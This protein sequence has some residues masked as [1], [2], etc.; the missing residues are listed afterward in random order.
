MIP[1]P[2]SP[3]SQAAPPSPLRSALLATLLALAL[4]AARGAPFTPG[5]FLV[6]EADTTS[7]E[8]ASKALFADEWA[9]TAAGRLAPVGNSIAL[10]SSGATPLTA[11]GQAADIGTVRPYSGSVTT[12]SDGLF[13]CTTGYQLQANTTVGTSNSGAAQTQTANAFNPPAPSVPRVIACIDY[14]QNVRIINAAAAM[15]ALF[16]PPAPAMFFSSAYWYAPSSGFFLTLGQTVSSVFPGGVY[17]A[18]MVGGLGGYMDTPNVAMLIATPNSGSTTNAKWYSYVTSFQGTLYFLRP[19]NGVSAGVDHFGGGVPFSAAQAAMGCQ[20]ATATCL[21]GGNSVPVVGSTTQ[22]G[23]TAGTLGGFDP[24]M[25]LFVSNSSGQLNLFVADGWSGLIMFPNCFPT[26]SFLTQT[27]NTPNP[28]VCTGSTAA[29]GAY[30]TSIPSS[31]GGAPVVKTSYAVGAAQAFISGVKAIVLTTPNGIW[32][33]PANNTGAYASS[34]GTCCATPTA[35]ACCWMNN[36]TAITPVAGAYGYTFRGIVP[37]PVAPACATPG[38]YC[39]SGS[40]TPLLCPAGSVCSGSGTSSV[41]PAGGFC[42]AGSQASV[43]PSPAGTFSD[44]VSGAWPLPTCPAGTFA[45]A[46]SASCTPCAAGNYTA[47][48]G[49]GACLSC[50]PGSTST[51]SST[52]CSACPANTFTAAP[53]QPCSPCPTGG[54]SLPGSTGCICGVNFVSNGQAGVQQKCTCPFSWAFAGAGASATCTAPAGAAFGSGGASVLVLRVGDGTAALSTSAAATYLD[55]YV[56]TAAVPVSATQSVATSL[57]VSGTDRTVGSLARSADGS[58]VSFAGVS[59]GPGNAP[60]ASAPFFSSVAPRTIARVTASGAVDTSTS[61]PAAA[62]DGIIRAACPFGSAGYYVVG[63]STVAPGVG[64]VAQGGNSVSSIASSPTDFVGCGVVGS[65]LYLLR[66]SGANAQGYPVA[67]LSSASPATGAGGALTPTSVS[68]GASAPPGALAY[69]PRAFAISVSG[70]RIFVGD[71]QTSIGAP[72]PGIWTSGDGGGSFSLWLAISSV[73]VTGLALAPGEQKLFYT[74]PGALYSVG[75]AEPLGALAGAVTILAVAPAGTEFRSLALPPCGAGTSTS[76]C[77]PCAL[78]SFSAVGGAATC[79][80]CPAGA[81]T[82]S[83][84]AQS[85]ASCLCSA[86]FYAT[87]TAPLACAACPAGS[88]S[89]AGASACICDN[90]WVR[91]QHSPP[92]AICGCAPK[93]PTNHI[94]PRHPTA[95]PLP[96]PAGCVAACHGH[97]LLG[98]FVVAV[99]NLLEHPLVDRNDQRD[100]DALDDEHRQPLRVSVLLRHDDSIAH[101]DALAVAEPDLGAERS[102]HLRLLAVTCEQ[103]AQAFGH[104]QPARAHDYNHKLLRLAARRQQRR[105]HK[106]L[107]CGHGPVGGAGLVRAPRARARRGVSGLQGRRRLARGGPGEDP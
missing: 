73:S 37:V 100:A 103:S 66:A 34:T 80:Q 18:P 24:H 97:V 65:T 83:V 85:S 20:L 1:P 67:Y 33:W 84:G 79:S 43:Q 61:L 17:W 12:S 93:Q 48:A 28:I 75:V 46:G 56:T 38:Y 64:F 107:R 2:P 29:L 63:N 16:G 36:N 57:V 27:M 15:A 26:A 39:A 105:D 78:G 51:A 88:T 19:S 54:V 4:P 96:P 10:P 94:P 13:A 71:L 8:T 90:T 42:P 92:P 14:A 45:P 102:V 95:L 87:S 72:N 11:L 68:I 101:G 62:Y 6:M 23:V 70:Q 89:A 59:T 32:L 3:P 9:V 77:V 82:A 98:A 55:E 50:P 81:T 76:Y 22:S 31:P 53:G 74:L 104:F 91:N 106:H 49:A 69:F 44:G 35:G 7:L 99:R 58:I 52:G 25:A 5:N 86:N 41:C 60:G 30:A 21:L 47:V 40:T